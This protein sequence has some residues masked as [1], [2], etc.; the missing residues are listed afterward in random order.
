M[1]LCIDIKHEIF[2]KLDTYSLF[3][4]AYI[5]SE[6]MDLVSYIMNKRNRVDLCSSAALMDDLEILKC[7]HN[8]H[9]IWSATS[10]TS[11]VTNNSLNCLKYL[12][13]NGCPFHMKKSFYE[14][15]VDSL[16]INIFTL[17]AVNNN[18][19][20]L[21]YLHECG[22]SCRVL[23][24]PSDRDCLL[25]LHEIDCL[26]NRDSS[27]N[28]AIQNGDMDLLK[29]LHKLGYKW[30]ISAYHNAI[31]RDN[32]ECIKYLYENNCPYNHTRILGGLINCAVYRN[33][34]ECLKYLHNIMKCIITADDVH[35]AANH[36]HLDI[37]KYFY[38][39]KITYDREQIFRALVINKNKE[40]SK[41]IINVI[42]FNG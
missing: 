27:C 35:L 14:H 25:Y 29:Y 8:M 30:D 37:L 6:D 9:Y 15:Q 7:L 20:C 40:C 26:D 24:P 19:E 10:M 33:K 31:S 36:G 28:I 11:A 42:L 32:I 23:S 1:V 12:Y 18:L 39:N 34:I 5:N 17:A 4:L 2:M 3:Q 16:G 13:E 41:Y 21:K 38:E 22:F